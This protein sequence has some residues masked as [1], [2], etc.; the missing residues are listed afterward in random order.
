MSLDRRLSTLL[1]PSFSWALSLALALS[2][3]A[4]KKPVDGP[5]LAPTATATATAKTAANPGP[6]LDFILD[7]VLRDNDW[8]PA[9]EA[10]RGKPSIVLVLASWD[11]SSLVQLRLLAP[12][13]RATAK[14]T[15]C[16]LVAMQPLGDRPLVAAF[17]DAED[18]PCLRAIGDPTRGRLGDLAKVQAIPSTIVLRADGTLVGVA[19]GVVD[20][21]AVKA[22]LEKAR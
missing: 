9:S 1:V 8:T 12:L 20:E 18:N 19:P 17:F 7:P 5:S 11:G 3:C 16:M 14:D 2:A 22:Q 4:P 21:A 10:L 13:L 6:P 15:N